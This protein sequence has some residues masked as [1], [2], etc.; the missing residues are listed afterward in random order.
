M[1]GLPDLTVK[2]RKA[3]FERLTAQVLVRGS[4][5]F[6]DREG[7]GLRQGRVSLAIERILQALLSR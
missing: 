2:G 6:A 3:G 1:D 5:R 7:R 4:L